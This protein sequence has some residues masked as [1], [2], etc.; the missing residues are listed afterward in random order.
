MAD[1]GEDDFRRTSPRFAQEAF[2]ANLALVERIKELAA[3]KGATPGQ[4]TLAWIA[5]KGDDIVSIPGTK[6]RTYLE[7]N[8]AAMDLT[9]TADELLRLE[10]LADGV[11]GDRY[12]DMRVINR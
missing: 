5:A 3:T 4:V 2:D 7:Q 9:L 6:R 11:V 1:L 8:A 10:E 12:A